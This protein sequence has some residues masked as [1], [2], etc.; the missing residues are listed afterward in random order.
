MSVDFITNNFNLII[1]SLSIT[2]NM[3]TRK[4]PFNH[5]QLQ[6]NYS[7]VIYI[8]TKHKPESY[9]MAPNIY[10]QFLCNSRKSGQLPS[11]KWLTA[12]SKKKGV[13]KIVWQIQGIPIESD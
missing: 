12:V 1:Y 10:F 8:L 6:Y 11:R 7:Y 9:F 2:Y 5:N 13:W 3:N 4:K